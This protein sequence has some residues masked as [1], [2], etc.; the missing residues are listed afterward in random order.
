MDNATFVVFAPK[1]K[2]LRLRERL[3]DWAGEPMPDSES[4]ARDQPR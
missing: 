4:F 1:T 3:R 2:R